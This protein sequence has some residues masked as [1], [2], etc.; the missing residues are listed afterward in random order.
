MKVILVMTLHTS[1]SDNEAF[2]KTNHQKAHNGLQTPMS[3]RTRFAYVSTLHLSNPKS[4]SL[5]TDNQQPDKNHYIVHT[6]DL[7]IFQKVGKPLQ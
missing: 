6:L 3:E 7:Q 2:Q 5:Q 1:S 4:V